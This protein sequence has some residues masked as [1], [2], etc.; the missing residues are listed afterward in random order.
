MMNQQIIIDTSPIVA[1]LSPK[2]TNHQICVDTLKTLQPPLIT[3]WSVITEV[4]WLIRKNKIGINALFTM[5][6]ADLLQVVHLPK[7]ATPWLKSYLLKYHDIGAQIA[8]VSLCYLAETKNINTIFTLD[9]RDFQIYRIKNNQ[10]L[11]IIP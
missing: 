2:D 6:E 8:D 4:L 3:C 7:E 5:I 9:K 11:N 1:I 10:T